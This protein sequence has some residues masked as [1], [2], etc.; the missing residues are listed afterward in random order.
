MTPLT[1]TAIAVF[2][3]SYFF[4][5]TERIH[6]TKVAVLGAVLLVLFHVLTQAEAFRF[7][8]F[9]TVGLLL[10]MMLLISV[11]KETGA[12]TYIAIRITKMTG[13]SRWKILLWFS[14]LTAVSSA[15]LDNVTTILLIAPITILIAEMLSISPFPFLISEILASNIGGTATL[16][17]DPPNILIGSATEIP[18]VDFLIHLGPA[19]LIILGVT[20]AVLG[21]LFRKDLRAGGKDYDSIIAEMDETKV[22]KN[23]GVLRKSILVLSLTIAG[24]LFHNMLGLKPATIALGGGGVLMVW[25]GADIEKHLRE[26]E[27]TTLFFFMGLFILVGG[28]EK[29][30]VLETLASS[31]V[32]LSE[33]MPFLCLAL[34]WVSALA[35][36][37][38]DNIPFVAAMIPLLMRISTTLFPNT[39]GLDEAAY[40][41]YLIQQ[42]LPLW[43]SLALGACLGGNGTIVG[44]SAN[45]VAAGFS[46]KT[47]TPLNFRNYFRYGFPLMII[48][49]IVATLYILIRYILI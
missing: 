32:N 47:R 18:F 31:I 37:F 35:S 33:N 44:A 10:G 49:I 36:S 4:I 8:D 12:F 17:G 23:R 41:T 22:I 9:N 5:I 45:L 34:L 48:S 28:L 6:R 43:W 14:A 7:I 27:W 1:V 3:L 46:E 40:H 39:Q 24:F 42:S 30:G 25:S 21:V 11:I 15:L 38:L 13:G 19:A 20:L 29:T 26:I 2:L 16:I